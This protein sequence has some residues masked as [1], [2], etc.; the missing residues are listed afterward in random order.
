MSGAYDDGYEEI[1]GVD[2]VE[3]VLETMRWAEKVVLR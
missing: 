2:V 3:E 1:V